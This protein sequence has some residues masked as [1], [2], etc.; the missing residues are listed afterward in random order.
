[1]EK[2]SSV[3]DM[4]RLSKRRTKRRRHTCLR[5]RRNR[6]RLQKGGFGDLRKES[7]DE[8]VSYYAGDR[9]EGVPTIMRASQIPQ[10]D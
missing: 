3:L 9:D 5:T 1:M 2:D 7:K 6:R 8:L 4:P 10:T